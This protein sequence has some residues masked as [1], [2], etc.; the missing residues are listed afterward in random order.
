MTCLRS[1]TIRWWQSSKPELA[2][3]LVDNHDTQPLQALEAPVEAWFKPMAYALILLRR[4]V[5]LMFFTPIFLALL[6]QIKEVTVTSMKV[7]LL[8]VIK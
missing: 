3:T 5:I 6:I 4:K 7:S 8:H 2:V 1:S